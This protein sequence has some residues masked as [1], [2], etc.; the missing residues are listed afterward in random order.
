M[1]EARQRL[2]D[3]YLHNDIDSL[4][5]Y[6]DNW[7]LYEQDL[8]SLGFFG[9]IGCAALLYK[10]IPSD[11]SILDVGCGPGN[12]GQY[13]KLLKFQKI[14][15]LDGSLK[16][17]ERAINRKVYDKVIHHVINRPGFFPVKNIDVLVGSGVFTVG[18]FPVDSMLTCFNA[19]RH[20]GYF[21]FSATNKVLDTTF[22]NEFTYVKEN[23]YL[24]DK[25]NIQSIVYHASKINKYPAR[26]YLFQKL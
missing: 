1:K 22:K 19:V 8:M 13:L 7:E 18:H 10:H 17:V 15:G 16:M 9:P 3:S 25:T 6:Y 2:Q 5:K 21:C 23:S 26:V 20:N 11:Y 4:L 14:T 12:L 24:I